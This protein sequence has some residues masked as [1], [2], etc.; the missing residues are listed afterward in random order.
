MPFDPGLQ[1]E[2]TLLAWRRTCLSLAVSG[3][4][5]VRFGASELG[6]LAVAAGLAS[7]I[8]AAMAYADAARRYRIV[9][10]HLNSGR[11]LPSGAIPITLAAASVAVFGLACVAWLV[12]RVA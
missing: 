12:V 5:L 9:H 1:P 10:R 4:L 8:L 7:V 11:A 6:L 2:R 3:L